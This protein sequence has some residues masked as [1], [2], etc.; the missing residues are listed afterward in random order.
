MHLTHRYGRYY[1]FRTQIGRESLLYRRNLV[2]ERNNSNTLAPYQ[3]L[4]HDNIDNLPLRPSISHS[5]LQN[6][7]ILVEIL[8]RTPAAVFSLAVLVNLIKLV[9]CTTPLPHWSFSKRI[10]RICFDIYFA[11]LQLALETPY[12]VTCRV[13]HTT[14]RSAILLKFRAMISVQSNRAAWNRYFV[15][16]VLLIGASQHRSNNDYYK[17]PSVIHFNHERRC[18]CLRA[19]SG[20]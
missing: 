1:R 15:S 18:Q 16:S 2:S 9:F 20:S 13:E 3:Y 19:I 6:L 17:Y 14:F 11:Q 8:N 7:P 5:Y 10:T 12:S 4:I